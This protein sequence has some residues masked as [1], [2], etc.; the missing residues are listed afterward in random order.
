MV[1]KQNNSIESSL[2]LIKIAS[3]PNRFKILNILSKEFICACR[4]ADSLG[5]PQNLVSHHLKVLL[6]SEILD[7][8]REGNNLYYFINPLKEEQIKK[9]F[10]LINFK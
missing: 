8:K 4:L 1:K 9:L 10:E 3:E 6:N 7:R 2:E 5:I